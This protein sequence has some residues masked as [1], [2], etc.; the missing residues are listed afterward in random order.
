MHGHLNVKNFDVNCF[1]D[2]SICY[3]ACDLINFKLL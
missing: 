2:S 3:K 1:Y